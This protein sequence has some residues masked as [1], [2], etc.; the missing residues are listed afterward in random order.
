V[1]EPFYFGPEER[2]LF[3]IYHQP[4]SPGNRDCAVV[5]CHPM[6][7][8]HIRS[9]RAFLQLALRLSRVGF[10]VLRFDL[11]GCGDSAGESDA[12]TISGWVEDA[13]MA[14]RELREGCG[15]RRLCLVGL[16]VGAAIAAFAARSTPTVD[17]LVLWDP[18]V[19]GRDHVRE[20]VAHHRRWL[21]GS[22]VGEMLGG[23]EGSL[24]EALGFPL[25][26]RLLGELESM[27]LCALDSRAAQR[28][29]VLDTGLTK[30]HDR[31]IGRLEAL[32]CRTEY[33]RIVDRSAWTK[34][35]ESLSRD[36]S[37]A[38]L[39]PARALDALVEWMRGA[40]S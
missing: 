7:Q 32:G 33:C 27:D 37:L 8:E 23:D 38:G 3:G 9:H 1:Y 30:D 24:R 6:G 25:S 13:L 40:F 11:F 5:L 29:L 12:G 36:G 10:S 35:K 4:L 2:R 28:S 19:R 18:V 14:V 16:R 21:R 31:L 34:H 22:L 15:A 26:R 39:V 20:L 17:C